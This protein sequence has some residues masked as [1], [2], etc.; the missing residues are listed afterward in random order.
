[1]LRV[2][3]IIVDIAPPGILRRDAEQAWAMFKDEKQ[4]GVVIVTL[5]EDLPTTEAVELATA[6][7][8]E[9]HLPIATVVV[10]QVID[11]LFTETE[12]HELL[13]PRDIPRGDPGNE[14]LAA[15]I[16]RA[17]SERVQADSMKKI[18]HGIRSRIV[19]L[20]RLL[21]DPSTPDAIRTLSEILAPKML[22]AS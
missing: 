10:N 14:G 1:M 12:R 20:P 16:R 11:F 3:K 6:I 17:V 7:D 9:L 18:E 4:S 8:N 5:P 21:I 13:Q 15:A 19:T 22:G 2:P